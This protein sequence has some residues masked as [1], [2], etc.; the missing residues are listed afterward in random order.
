MNGMKPKFAIVSTNALQ[1]IGMKSLLEK[2]APKA[3]VYIYYSAEELSAQVSH[4]FVHYFVSSEIVR[5]CPTLF[6]PI[7]RQTIVMTH[8]KEDGCSNALI[9]PHGFHTINVNVPANVLLKEILRLMQQG[10]AHMRPSRA[11]RAVAMKARER[12]ETGKL[13]RREVEVLK[14]V[15]LGRSSKEIAESLGV[16]P[17]TII[18]HRKS[19]MEKL[20]AHSATKLVIYAVTHGL[21][22]PEEII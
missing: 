22:R 15:A 21:V 19:I 17:S 11:A 7:A 20:D 12:A 10:H 8:G 13:T 9:R 18:S 5:A 14:Q 2:L 4:R 3:E 6:A 1:S 16:S